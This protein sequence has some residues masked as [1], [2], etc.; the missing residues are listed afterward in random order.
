MTKRHHAKKPRAKPSAAK[1][2]PREGGVY[3]DLLAQ[4]AR[5]LWLPHDLDEM[6]KAAR[7]AAASVLLEDINPAAGVESLLAVQMVATHVAALECLRRAMAGEASPEGRDEHLKHAER[8]LGIYTRQ[9]D[10]LGRHRTRDQIFK[11]RQEQE[12]Q[13]AEPKIRPIM[14]HV[15]IKPD[16]T[17]DGAEDMTAV[18]ASR[19]AEGKPVITP[20]RDDAQDASIP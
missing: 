11:Q 1:H 19:L 2:A 14:R 6:E 7:L 12:R 16:G 8:L 10:V 5:T 4:L 13:A 3:S 9:M 18:Y 17:V 20:A 15:F